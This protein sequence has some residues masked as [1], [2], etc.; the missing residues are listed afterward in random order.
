MRKIHIK[1]T[2]SFFFF[3]DTMIVSKRQRMTPID[4]S[5]KE[6]EIL[7]S[8]A[9]D[10][11]QDSHWRKQNG[12]SLWSR[13]WNYHLTQ[14]LHYWLYMQ[15]K[16]NNHIGTGTGTPLFITAMFAIAKT[17]TQS[18]HQQ[19]SNRRKSDI[20]TEWNVFFFI[21]KKKFWHLQQYGWNDK[22]L[23]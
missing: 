4:R 10:T 12:R 1:I 13:G 20:W 11:K 15:N 5:V 7:Y 16:W 21:V 22:T 14:E 6:M 18:T 2:V 19:M 8:V 9:A 17:Q 3:E 23:C